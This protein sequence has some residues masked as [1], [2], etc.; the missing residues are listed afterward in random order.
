[1]ERTTR[2]DDGNESR[3]WSR[4]AVNLTFRSLGRLLS[5][6]T[7][8][9]T[10]M[11][12]TS[13]EI[14]HRLRQ[15]I[16]QVINTLDES[17]KALKSRH[18]EL[19]PISCLPSDVLAAIFSFL[20]VFSWDEGYGIFALIYVTHVCRRW[21]EIALNHPP[22]WSRIDITELT[23][24]GMA[25]ILARVKMAPLHL[26]ADTIEWE[27]EHLETLGTYLYTHISHTRDLKIRG[28][29]PATVV[30]RLVSPAPIL[31]SLSLSESNTSNVIPDNLFKYTTPSLTSLKLEGFRIRH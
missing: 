8:T 28:Y 3:D 15:I 6:Q 10:G 26:E 9:I 5:T 4:D 27:T 16:D 24:V 7:S 13:P 19:S 1:M 30:D 23:P 17:T 18:N 21:R 14:P 25:E 11:D 12:T 29:L 22:F 20:S 2:A 31:K